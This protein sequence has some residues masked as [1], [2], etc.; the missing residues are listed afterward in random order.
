MLSAKDGECR[1]GILTRAF[2]N[3]YPHV[4]ADENLVDYFA[5]AAVTPL[6]GAPRR[7]GY[8][9]AFDPLVLL[10]ARLTKPRTT[11]TALSHH[12]HPFGSSSP[13][14]VAGSW[15]CVLGVAPTL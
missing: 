8:R 2:R 9:H 11:T 1:L 10:L 4:R 5:D 14:D 15:L 13:G 7:L 3:A 12:S 6:T